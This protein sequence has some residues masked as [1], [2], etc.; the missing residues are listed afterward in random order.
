MYKMEE[1][2]WSIEDFQVGKQLGKG[3]FGQVHLARHQPK[4]TRYAVKTMDFAEHHAPKRVQALVQAEIANH[5]K[6]T[7]PNVI[8]LHGVMQVEECIYHLVLE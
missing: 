8:T 5:T 4:G 7:H 3:K 6:V 2:T 1:E